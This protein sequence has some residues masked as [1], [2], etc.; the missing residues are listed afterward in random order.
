[1]ALHFTLLTTRVLGLDVSSVQH[2]I[3]YALSQNQIEMILF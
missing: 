1:M 2:S 3:G